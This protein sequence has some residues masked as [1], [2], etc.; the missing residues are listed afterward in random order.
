MSFFF[1]HANNYLS[2]MKAKE[3]RSWA[4]VKMIYN[5]V[6]VSPV[7]MVPWPRTRQESIDLAFTT[8]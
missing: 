3:T 5:K 8:S 1:C 6:T 2:S 4:A 7:L